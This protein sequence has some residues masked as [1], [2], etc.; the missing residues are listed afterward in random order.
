M[1]ASAFE[2]R[3]RM[4]ILVVVITLGFWSPW[5][6]AWGVGQRVSLFEW[7]ATELSRLGLVDFTAA[8]PIVI[9]L[10]S[11]LAAA[12]VVLRVWGTAYLGPGVVTN[13]EMKAGAVLADGPYR[14][15]RNPLYLGSWCMVAAMSFIAPPTGALFVMAFLT[16]FLF[17]LILGEEAFL[18]AQLGEPYLAYLR[19]VPR[20]LP[21]LRTN[22]QPAGR[23]PDWGKAIVSELNPVGVFF[24]IA[25]LSW[26]YDNRLM[27]KGILISFGVSLLMRAAL[28]AV[29]R[30]TDPL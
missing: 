20:L 17:R 22:L 16:I 27:L 10:A 9:V 19:A 25:V 21:R 13:T 12:A 6:E 23:K 4:A 15:M 29:R 18:A 5:I 14:Y 8:T 11:L 7:S 3:F 2:F 24:T 28:P 30:E 1:R 26:R